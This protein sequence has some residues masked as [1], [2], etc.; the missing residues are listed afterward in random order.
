MIY[1]VEVQETL[2]RT[3]TIQAPDKYKALEYAEDLYRNQKI[4]LNA[5]DFTD[6]EFK[7]VGE[8]A[9][10]NNNADFDSSKDIDEYEN[11]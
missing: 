6:S 1:T 7:V 11:E 4:V 9:D 3:V 5:D 10:I 2:S 8:K